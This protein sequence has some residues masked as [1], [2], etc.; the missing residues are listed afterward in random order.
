MPKH[1]AESEAT[2]EAEDG[3]T[4]TGTSDETVV[5]AEAEVVDENI[6]KKTNKK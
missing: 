4:E 3:T 5:D 2:A 1:A 6:D